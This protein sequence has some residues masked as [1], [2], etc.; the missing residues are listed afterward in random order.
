[1]AVDTHQETTQAPTPT[2]WK[3]DAEGVRVHW[4]PLGPNHFPEHSH[5]DCQ[6]SIPFRGAC[7]RVQ[8]LTEDGYHCSGP[9][10][11]GDVCIVPSHQLHRIEWR[12][13]AHRVSFYLSPDFMKRAAR[14]ESTGDSFE[15]VE[16]YGVRDATVQ[17]LGTLLW[18]ELRLGMTPAP[19]F[20]ESLGNVLAVHLLRNYAASRQPVLQPNRGLTPQQLRRAV[21]YIQDN[22]TDSDRTLKLAAIAEAV[23]MSPYHFAREFKQSTGQ[24]PHHYIMERRIERA[25][26]LLADGALSVA[27]IAYRTGFASQS[28]LSTLFRRFTKMSPSTYRQYL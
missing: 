4:H 23:G 28:H 25:K 14:E 22:L 9:L 15:L 24:A 10:Q 20:L 27:E 11:E 12:N 8:W 7:F 13:P 6:V 16:H 17:Q 3:L 5:S 19:M 2:G 1:M 18:S 21:A 26:E